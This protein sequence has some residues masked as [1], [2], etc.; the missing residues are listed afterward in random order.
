M[1]KVIFFSALQVW[2]L[3]DKIGAPSFF[4]TINGYVEAGW[5]VVLV[6]PDTGIAYS[7]PGVEIIFLPPVATHGY[8]T[9]PLKFADNVFYSFKIQNSMAKQGKKILSSIRTLDN[10]VIY[11]YEVHAVLACA[12]LAQKYNCP[13][14]TRFQGTIMSSKPCNF[15]TKIGYFPHY[16]ALR[17]KADL[18]IM[19]DDG[20]QGKQYLQQIGNTSKMLFLR[21]GVDISCGSDNVEKMD[22][23]KNKLGIS[24]DYHILMTLSRLVEWKRVDR[25]IICLADIIKHDI[26]CKLVILGDGPARKNLE[27]LSQ[28]LGVSEHVIFVGS[29]DHSNVIQYLAVADVF[30]SLYDLSNVGN[31]LYEA[32]QCGKAIVTLDNGDTGTVVKN[33]YNG[34]L[35]AP[36]ELDSLPNVVIDLLNNSEKRQ[37]IGNNAYNFSQEKLWS[38]QERISYEIKE[39]EKLLVR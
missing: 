5:D 30:L 31:P 37:R 3:G 39:V 4:Q 24:S 23:I 6:I 29:V 19:T 34:I 1:K 7:L 11:A 2:S 15:M 35:I 9:L 26:S 25:A 22:S 10:V 13:L 27:S 20:T 38:W 28:S 36:D 18:V 21:N 32:M 17:R 14:V 16:Q 12:Y 33:N 8:K